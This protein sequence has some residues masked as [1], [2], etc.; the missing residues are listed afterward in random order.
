MVLQYG[1][2]VMD[3]GLY[4][5]GLVWVEGPHLG[6]P[7]RS[8][9]TTPQ[10]KSCIFC[11]FWMVFT[12][13]YWNTWYFICL[14]FPLT[15][16]FHQVTSKIHLIF[17]CTY[18]NKIFLLIFWHHDYHNYSFWFKIEFW[19]FVAFL[20]KQQSLYSEAKPLTLFWISEHMKRDKNHKSTFFSHNAIRIEKILRTTFH[21]MNHTDFSPVRRYNLVRYRNMVQ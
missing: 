10:W 1:E 8:P 3:A 19:Y 12:L 14:S 11:F 6:T 15:V 20:H 13:K 17:I 4:C 21:I 7:P 5:W 16:F 9:P 2:I 18:C